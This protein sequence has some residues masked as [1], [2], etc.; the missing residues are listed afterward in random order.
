MDLHGKLIPLVGMLKT[1]AGDGTA[2]VVA[3]VAEGV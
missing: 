1:S 3:F 2:A